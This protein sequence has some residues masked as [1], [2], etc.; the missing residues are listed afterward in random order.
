MPGVL[1]GIRVLDFGRYIAGPYC[2]CMLAEHGAEVIRIEK[3]TASEDR[4]QAPIT[5]T[6]EGALFMQMNRNKLGMTLD[7]MKP[8]GQ[9]I[10]RKLVATADVVVANLPPQTLEAMKLDYESLKAVK[11]DIIL[12]TVTAYGRG[13]PYSDRV[14][15]DGIGQAMSGAV[16]M[17]SEADG[18]R[19]F[20]AQV[21]WVD[22]GTALHCA[23]GT[24]AALMARK[25]T[26]RG[27]WVE[28]ALLATA[29]TFGNAL[30]VEQAV[31]KPD[32]VPTANRGQTAAPVDLFK[33][34]DGVW[35]LVQV[36]GDPLY[37]RWAKLMG[38]EMWLTDPRFKTD[39]AR[40]DNGAVISERM[41][42]WCA[43][44]TSAEALEIL[45]KAAIPSGPVLKPQQT[46][47]DP[48]INAMGFFQPTEFPGMA[49][50]APIAKV[51]V[52]LSATP[53]GIRHRAPK[54]GEHTDMI[55]GKLGYDKAAIAAL[56][57][58]KII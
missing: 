26:G 28:G 53:G 21:P 55:L 5:P 44:Y 12:T 22:F 31:A 49:K 41:A 19:P 7:P 2:A 24:M 43:D 23:F 27:Q 33:C 50:P 45:A 32:R 10:V 34:K 11:E 1:E 30:L 57:E 47:D 17:T 13:G 42:K 35:I 8:E 38:E 18:E 58:K 39:I 20:R 9:E 40:G 29:V 51:P 15:F 16:Y 46:L 52:K 25:M 14:G 56:R 48:H 3:R 4:V 54:L 37:K 6:G 36:I